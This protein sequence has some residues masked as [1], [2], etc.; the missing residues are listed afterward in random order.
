M[1]II[2]T[3]QKNHLLEQ[4]LEQLHQESIEWL[5][6]IAFWKDEVAFLYKVIRQ[7]TQQNPTEMKSIKMKELERELLHISTDELEVLMDG[8][9][10]HERYLSRVLDNIQLDESHYRFKH[11]RLSLK[12]MKFRDHFKALKRKIFELVKRIG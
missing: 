4:P 7:K 12:M 11:R 1:K 5:D 9:E 2:T 6:K 8:I 10:L 3:H